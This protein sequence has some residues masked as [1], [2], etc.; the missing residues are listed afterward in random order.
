M[1]HADD[2]AERDYLGDIDPE[3]QGLPDRLRAV[4]FSVTSSQGIVK[5][6]RLHEGVKQLAKLCLSDQ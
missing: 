1:W 2:M 5:G 4:G 6:E 3:G